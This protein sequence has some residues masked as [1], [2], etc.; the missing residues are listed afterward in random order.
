MWEGDDS[1]LYF[2][3]TESSDEDDSCAIIQ[4]VPPLFVLFFSLPLPVPKGQSWILWNTLSS[5]LGLYLMTPCYVSIWP[6]PGFWT[7]AMH[8]C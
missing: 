7:A 6:A 1:Q 2:I 4:S 5:V 8:R 3:L